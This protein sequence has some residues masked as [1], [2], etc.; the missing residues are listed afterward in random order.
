M[1]GSW[2]KPLEFFASDLYAFPDKD[3]YPELVTRTGRS[4][5][6]GFRGKPGTT[7]DVWVENPNAMTVELR[8][9]PNGS[10]NINVTGD[11]RGAGWISVYDVADDTVSLGDVYVRVYPRL[12]LY[13]NLFSVRDGAGHWP[14]TSLASARQHIKSIN[15]FLKPQ[16]GIELHVHMAEG[17]TIT[18]N[19]AATPIASGTAAESE[20]WAAL[21]E[22]ADKF[23]RSAEH[24]YLYF[25]RRWGA[26]D[27]CI[28]G[29]CEHQVIGTGKRGQRQ[30][31]VEDQTNNFSFTTLIAH[32][33]M[34]SIGMTHN[35]P[36][37]ECALMYPYIEGNS[38]IFAEDVVEVR[39]EP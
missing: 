4:R 38:D 20:I 15:D 3:H 27:V 33:L 2:L 35:E 34:H 10:H 11:H 23:D 8:P 7:Y 30:C 21:K 12:K 37:G 9:F 16:T 13:V 28:G 36:R 32:E 5:L 26:R 25:L 6:F 39:G 24:L 17:F 14:A 29:H 1:S 19:A 18:P 22:E 31:V